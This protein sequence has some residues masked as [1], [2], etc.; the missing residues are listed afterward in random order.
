[1]SLIGCDSQGSKI[2]ME[3]EIGFKS[4]RW[5]TTPGKECFSDT[6]GLMHRC[7]HRDSNNM[8]SPG[9]APASQNP[10]T[11]FNLKLLMAQKAVKNFSRYSTVQAEVVKTSVIAPLNCLCLF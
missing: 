8:A 1:M 11:D 7:T 6:K 5:G 2:Y 10:R 9:K 3:E 4:Q